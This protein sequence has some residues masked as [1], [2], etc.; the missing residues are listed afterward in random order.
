MLKKTFIIV[1]GL[2]LITFS[3]TPLVSAHELLPKQLL[4]FTKQ[5]PDASQQEIED[6]LNANPTI[7]QGKDAHYREQIIQTIRHPRN[8]FF[9]NGYDFVKLGI[10]HILSGPDHILFVI[11]LVLVYVSLRH[12]LR[13]V[14]A[15][16]ISHSI[17]LILAG[18]GI[19]TLSSR[20][21]EPMIAL[22]IAYVALGSTIFKNNRWLGLGK[23]H[24]KVGAVFAFGLFHGLGFA[25][26]LVDLGI[27][28]NLFISSLLSFNIGIEL[29]Q[30]LI[31]SLVI[32][33]IYLFRHKGWYPKVIT[34]VAILISSLAFF[35]VGQRLFFS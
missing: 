13:M 11:S 32:P 31:L 2:F 34:I 1:S 8:G 21:V 9:H 29:G 4:E 27:P 16:T 12:T 24:N 17:T 35:W 20:I 19:L 30:L 22:S 26:L 28:N 25:G 7:L 33:L 23:S 10:E 14:S 6:Y 18:T 3:F 15:F 5:H